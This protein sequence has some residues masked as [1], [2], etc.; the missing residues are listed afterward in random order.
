M[1]PSHESDVLC[2]QFQRSDALPATVVDA[3]H[4]AR[5]PARVLALSCTGAAVELERGSGSWAP[6]PERILVEFDLEGHPGPLLFPATA[7]EA[8]DGTRVELNF[9]LE[10]AGPLHFSREALLEFLESRRRALRRAG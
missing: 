6:C 5:I 9:V 4:A 1:I 3:E 7:R 2:I 8:G 10:G